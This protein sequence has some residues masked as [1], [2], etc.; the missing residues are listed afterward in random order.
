MQA[1][2]RPQVLSL[3]SFPNQATILQ[4]FPNQATSAKPPI[5]P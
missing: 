2:M 5:I 4:S 3:P 1:W